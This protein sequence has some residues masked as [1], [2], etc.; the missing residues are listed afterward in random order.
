MKKHSVRWAIREAARVETITAERKKLDAVA[1][2]MEGAFLREAIR[3]R[4]TNP[5]PF[6]SRTSI[7]GRSLGKTATATF[8]VDG[9]VSVRRLTY[10]PGSGHV[11]IEGMRKDLVENEEP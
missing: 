10:Y 6:T 11:E 9:V 5:Q 3:T 2:R 8:P 1:E 7:L 4:Y